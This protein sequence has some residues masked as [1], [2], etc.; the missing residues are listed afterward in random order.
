[1]QINKCAVCASANL[2]LVVNQKWPLYSCR[3]CGL[4]QVSPTPSKSEVAKLYQG[5]YWKNYDFYISQIPAHQKYFKKK[6]E[7]IKKYRKSGKLLDVGCATGVFLREAGNNG[8]TA[9]GIDIS[10][11]A[12]SLCQ[13]HHLSAKQGVVADIEKANYYDIV[14]LFEVVEHEP[15]PLSVIKSVKKLLKNHGLLVVTVPDSASLSARL[16]GPYWFGYRNKEHLFH[17]S[18][19]S[20]D[21]LLRKQ[22]FQSIKITKDTY[23][24]YLATYYLERLNY[25]LF[26]SKLVGKII[27]FLKRIPGFNRLTIPLNPWGNLIAFAVKKNV[28]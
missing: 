4:V 7:E 15:N 21:L 14:T 12:V 9:D 11:Y 1:M 26:Q 5:D 23:R 2:M 20:L 17:F 3:D 19:K 28:D 13:K 18:K 6:I 24:A 22:G 8:F 25:Y 16:M 10:K 27:V